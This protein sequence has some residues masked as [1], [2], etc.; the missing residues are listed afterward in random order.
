[1][2]MEHDHICVLERSL[3]RLVVVVGGYVLVNEPEDRR[4]EEV[5]TG[6]PS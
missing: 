4:P 3:R 2:R 1:M 5:G 6:K